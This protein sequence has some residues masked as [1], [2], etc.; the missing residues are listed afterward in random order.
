MCKPAPRNLTAGWGHLL[1]I[2]LSTI[3]ILDMCRCRERWPCIFFSNIIPLPYICFLL[4][5]GTVVNSILFAKRRTSIFA[6]PDAVFWRRL[7]RVFRTD[8]A[9]RVFSYLG[10]IRVLHIFIQLCSTE[11]NSAYNSTVNWQIIALF[12]SFEQAG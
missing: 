12:Q 8:G 7:F 6:V 10:R 11:R 1:C 2:V 3:F 5:L 4:H 9:L